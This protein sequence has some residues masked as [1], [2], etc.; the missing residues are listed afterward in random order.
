ME[1]LINY[2]KVKIKINLQKC[3]VLWWIREGDYKEYTWFFIIPTGG[4][5][6]G[7]NFGFQINKYLSNG[8]YKKLHYPITPI[9]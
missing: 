4:Y 3:W 1:R 5:I 6:G 2:K 8:S 9:I 7:Y